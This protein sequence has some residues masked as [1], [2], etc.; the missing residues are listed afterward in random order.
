MSWDADAYNTLS[1]PQFRW[2]TSLLNRLS[3]HGSETVL[4][5][6]CGSGRLTAELLKRLPHGHV[7][8]F[9]SS[10]EMLEKARVQLAPAAGRIEFIQADLSKF[11][12]PHPVD[13]VF[14]N[15]AFHWVPNHD[16]MFG[17]IFRALRPGGWLLAQFGGEGNL[18]RTRARVREI[19]R[20]EPYASFLRAWPED[21]HY[22]SVEDTVK[23]LKR[24]GF[25]SIEARLHAEPVTFTDASL[26]S[27]FAEKV[28]LHRLMPMLS[29]ELQ[30]AF[31]IDLTARAS[32]DD[33]PF[34]LD[35]VRLTIR[36]HRP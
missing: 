34:T 11:D 13:G 12:L 32:H 8:A 22:E 36:A 4:D 24:A 16:T 15:A 25:T 6:G 23:R 20:G 19:G 31:L 21:P 30:R 17:S 10:S 28:I 1:D 33:P 26:F 18:R 35:Y 14:S 7:I 27:R 2:G 29:T 5:A 9:D 3:L